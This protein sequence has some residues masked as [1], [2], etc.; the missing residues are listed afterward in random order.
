[1]YKI[2]PEGKIVAE[3]KREGRKYL[4]RDFHLLGDF[5]LVYCGEQYGDEG[6]MEFLTAYVKG[7]Y[8][9][10]IAKIK[11]DGLPALKEWI[12]HIY[13]IEESSELLHTEL[14]ENTLTVTIDRSP[15]IEYMAS[16]NQ[17]PSKYYIEETRTLYRVIAEES[18][19]SFELLYYN[20]DGA[21][22]FK[23]SK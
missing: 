19:L 8:S 2:D 7:Y 22:S 5:A 12:E 4:H 10:I 15:V 23:F 16:L 18:G 17:K 9:P 6:V 21:T 13:E 3:A 14:S 11:E 1:M 20:E